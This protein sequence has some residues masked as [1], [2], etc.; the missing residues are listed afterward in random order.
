MLKYILLS[1]LNP[2]PTSDHHDTPA[3]VHVIIAKIMRLHSFK[4]KSWLV[5]T[6][7]AEA[8]GIM[9]LWRWT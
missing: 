4:F 1:T 8:A 3:G 9:Y 6:V 5:V 7:H 2:T